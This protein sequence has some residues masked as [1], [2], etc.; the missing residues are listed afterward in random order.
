[1]IRDSPKQLR[2]SPEQLVVSPDAVPVSQRS[3][4]YRQ[5]VVPVLALLGSG[6]SPE[7]LAWSL[8]LGLLVGI[9]PLLGSTTVLCLALAFV[10]R[11]NLVASQITN[12]AVYPFQLLMV[13]PFLRA[14]SLLFDTAPLPMSGPALLHAARSHPLEL[15]RLLWTWEW[16]A[17]VVWSAVSLVGVPVAAFALTPILRRLILRVEQQPIS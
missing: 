3:W 17:L 1:M 14:G 13:L 16:H 12:H 5:L 2:N 10:L 6:A 4:I 15:I 8:A 7:K 9:N 11:L